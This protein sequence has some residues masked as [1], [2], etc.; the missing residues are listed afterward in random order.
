MSSVR[1]RIAPSP[2][3][4]LHIGTARTALFNFLFAKHHQGQFILRIEDTDLERSEEQYVQ[5]IY[6]GLKKLGLCWDEGPDIGGAFGPYVQSERLALYQEWAQTLV[7]QGDAYLCYLND[8]ELEAL[9]QQ[10]AEQKRP[11][12]YRQNLIETESR[13]ALQQ[14]PT[15]S[16][17]IRFRVPL[18]EPEIVFQDLIRGEVRFDT[19][20]IGDF[21]ILKSNGTPSY[22]FAVVVDDLTMQI[23]HVIR[24]EDHV[25]NTPR[26]LMLY[27]ALKHNPP[28][29]AHV[30]MILAPDRTKLS[31]RHG[32]TAVSDYIDQGY[33]PEAFC[34]FLSLLGW[35]LPDGQEVSSLENLIHQFELTRVAH[36]PAIFDKDK[37][38]WFNGLYI[39]Q[40]PLDELLQRSQKYLPEWLTQQYSDSALQL[41]LGAVREPLKTLS[42]LPAALHYF[43]KGP[44]T[45]DA[46]VTEAV[47][48]DAETQNIL[49]RVESEFLPNTDFSSPEG[50]AAAL[51]EFT[52]QLKPLKVKTILWAIRAAVTGQVHGAD[53]SITLHLLGKPVVQQRL[54]QALEHLKVLAY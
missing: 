15:R 50:I 35:S 42:E 51:K 53:L 8:A 21:V 12:V 49:R 1:V 7:D 4:N 9:R 6:D 40:C 38:D 44:V 34:N 19:T 27:K 17:S 13:N 46:Q 28:L 45:Y 32:A 52:Q 36:S 54:E 5:N 18:D 10:A 41:M 26:Q 37:L 3:G 43:A 24:G 30:G 16:P 31:K 20:L 2:T 14:D 29:F 33:L 48:P 22:N 39:R 25:S 11:F 23:S 47:W